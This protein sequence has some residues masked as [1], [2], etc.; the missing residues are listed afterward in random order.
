MNSGGRVQG[1]VLQ[2]G[3]EVRSKVVL[4]NASPQITFLKLTPQVRPAGWRLRCAPRQ[5]LGNGGDRGR[6]DCIG[7]GY[8]SAKPL[9]IGGSQPFSFLPNRQ[10]ANRE[11]AGEEKDPERGGAIGHA[12]GSWQS[13]TMNPCLTF[14]PELFI[15]L[16]CC[17]NF[18]LVINSNSTVC[19]QLFL[20]ECHITNNYMTYGPLTRNADLAHRAGECS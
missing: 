17:L 6:Q 9:C 18:S 11:E 15:Q 12:A 20:Y 1:V 8:A 14:N 3:S 5:G 2:D 10:V 4:S 13:Q 16:F 19:C 7:V